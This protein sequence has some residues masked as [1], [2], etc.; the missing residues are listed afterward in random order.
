MNV[1]TLGFPFGPAN[2]APV[3]GGAE[4]GFMAALDAATGATTAPA[5]TAMPGTQP[6]SGAANPRAKAP[7]NT[8]APEIPANDAAAETPQSGKPIVPL[9]QLLATATRFE[10]SGLPRVTLPLQ[11]AMDPKLAEAI[12]L[13][14]TNAAVAAPTAATPDAA[15]PAIAATATPAKAAAAASG[16]GAKTVMAG[17]GPDNALAEPLPCPD[18]QPL[19]QPTAAKARDIVVTAPKGRKP[20]AIDADEPG[21]TPVP[22]LPEPAATPTIA[23]PVVQQPPQMQPQASAAKYVQGK[24][25]GARAARM[26]P[27][28]TSAVTTP[29]DTAPASDSSA[30]AKF[31]TLRPMTGVEGS[32]QGQGQQADAPAP[33]SNFAAHVAAP[34]HAAA[35]SAPA[36]TSTPAAPAEP[37]V[38]ARPGEIGH[39]IGVEIARKVEAGEDTL[40]VRLNPAELGRVE[41]TLAF[42]SDGKLNATM[43]AE[44]AH[45]LDLLRQDAPD[46]GRAL[47][48]AGIRSD[49][50]SF[51]FESR[52]GGGGGM[53]GQSQGQQQQSRGGRQQFNEEPE[54]QTPAWRAVRADGQVDLLA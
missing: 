28:G 45:A 7:A 48:Q 44:S 38:N 8:N 4:Q 25:E 15:G 52:D 35:T 10:D 18:P 24:V 5:N 26:Q 23:T 27:A 12:K 21:E 54:T 47:D 53:S 37:V 29:G 49:A 40:R 17:A 46:L 2:G 11:P 20:V 6:A 3:F 39:G 13:A 33:Q 50:Q 43:R 41:V 34:I 9:S 51:R 14:Q 32:V 31:E 16:T 22:T 19:E 1:T 30:T 42:D 36:T